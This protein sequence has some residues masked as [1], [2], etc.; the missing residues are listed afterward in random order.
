MLLSSRRSFL[1]TA[2][3]LL[4]FLPVVL[5]AW[6]IYQ[7]SVDVLLIDEWNHLQTFYKLHEGLINIDTL[8]RT[9]NGQRSPVSLLIFFGL[10]WITHW[11]TI[12]ILWCSL[13][14][15]LFYFLVLRRW[16]LS[17]GAFTSTSMAYFWIVIASLLTF[18]LNQYENWLLGEQIS[19]FLCLS[20]ALIGLFLLARPKLTVANVAGAGF[21]G[22]FSAL[23]SGAGLAFWPTSVLLLGFRNYLEKTPHIQRT[24]AVW[25]ML[26]VA[27]LYLY[28]QGLQPGGE[29]SSPDFLKNHLLDLPYFF[30]SV[31]GTPI[32]SFVASQNPAA[33]VFHAGGLVFFVGMLSLISFPLIL[34][35]ILRRKMVPAATLYF[36]V[37]IM[38]FALAAAAMITVA[39]LTMGL[40]TAYASRYI[41]FTTPFWLGLTYFG[42]IVTTHA[43]IWGSKPGRFF[44]NYSGL[45]LFLILICGIA[46]STWAGV[47]LPGRKQVLE[48]AR[49]ELIRGEVK[50]YL[51]Y[52]HPGAPHF[53]DEGRP[54]LQK[55]GYSVFRDEQA[56]MS[57]VRP[58]ALRDF[59]QKI[60]LAGSIEK[61]RTN[62][63]L[64]IPLRITNSGSL[65]WSY[66]GFNRSQF[67]VHIGY[68]W[69]NG[70]NASIQSEGRRTA[71][72]NDLFP[73]ETILI[74][75]VIDTPAQAGSHI[76][77][78]SMVQEGVNWF[79]TAAPP[80]LDLPIYV[81]P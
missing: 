24:A 36:P 20:S 5:V 37:S 65:P 60:E 1:E 63:R 21:L 26:C 6:V 55:L 13:F 67:A 17:E 70:K 27:V 80:C 57:P 18:S 30:C 16:A 31:I 28:L 78:V 76:L 22:I 73:G 14:I 51:F 53:V 9:Q 10:I 49:R 29:T 61:M 74:D 64:T 25:F 39:R 69:L 43:G 45:G 66:F 3:Q 8:V 72:P 56:E 32:L 40:P 11:N 19:V 48:I 50:E 46:G 52:L 4:G 44:A 54:V 77:R 38:T 47:L 42:V 58:E 79:C 33:V 59:S 81:D 75:A 62:R 35:F 71:L 2:L 23:S 41:S 15:C 68:F 12:V 7:Y 34:I